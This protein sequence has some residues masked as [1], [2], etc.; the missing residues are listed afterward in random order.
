MRFKRLKIV[1]QIIIISLIGVLVP[2]VISWF[3]INNV[4]QHSLRQELGYSAQIIAKIIENN[5]SSILSADNHRLD[6]IVISLNHI[7]NEH[8]KNLY[9]KNLAINS[10]I[11]K[12]FEIIRPSETPD[13]DVNDRIIYNSG[14]ERLWL[15]EKIHDDKYLKAEIN[16][17]LIKDNIFSNIEDEKSR[18]VYIVDKSGKLGSTLLSNGG[19][20]G[21]PIVLEP[22]VINA[23]F[24]I[25][26][27]PSKFSFT[28][29]VK[30]K[31]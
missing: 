30:V 18:R 14:S 8:Q 3:V 21:V 1:E 24:L 31:L 12:N 26:P 4:S 27:I 2:S 5:I 13:F 23:M 22:V 19:K 29:T 9:L 10:E 7:P 16:T 20:L 17:K 11:F 25:L 28:L 15:T 6:E